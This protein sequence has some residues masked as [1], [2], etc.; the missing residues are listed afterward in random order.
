M[1]NQEI[2]QPDPLDTLL[3]NAFKEAL[4]APVDQAMVDRVLAGIARRQRQ[5]MLVLMLSGLVALAICLL[6]AMPLLELLPSLFSGLTG[7]D[8]LQTD[9]Q[10]SLPVTLAAVAIAVAGGWLLLE[11]ATA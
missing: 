1:S 2:N 5:R 9:V 10:L 11:E 6:G 7:V 8:G 4:S 3:S